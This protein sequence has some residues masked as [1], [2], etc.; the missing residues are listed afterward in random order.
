MAVQKVVNLAALKAGLMV[1]KTAAP[2]AAPKAD[3]MAAC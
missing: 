2:L 3:L 1:E